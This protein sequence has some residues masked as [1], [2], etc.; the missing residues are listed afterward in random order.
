MRNVDNSVDDIDVNKNDDSSAHIL[1]PR[2]CEKFLLQIW[3]QN[4]AVCKGK[5]VDKDKVN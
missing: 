3:S 1:H 4:I 2:K 5:D